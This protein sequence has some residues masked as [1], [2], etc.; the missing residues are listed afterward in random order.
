MK[1]GLST[2]TSSDGT[3]AATLALNLSHTGLQPAPVIAASVYCTYCC[4]SKIV[5]SLTASAAWCFALPQ[6]LEDM[7]PL[8]TYRGPVPPKLTAGH[9]AAVYGDELWVFPGPRNHNMMRVYCCDLT[10]YRWTER[11]VRGEPPT[12][13]ESRRNLDCFLDGKRLIVFGKISASLSSIVH[14]LTDVTWAN[15][16]TLV[17][18]HWVWQHE[19]RVDGWRMTCL[20]RIQQSAA[21]QSWHGLSLDLSRRGSTTCHSICSFSLAALPFVVLHH[22]IRQ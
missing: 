13:S 1:S 9:Y 5:V 21:S 8:Q 11:E 10:R 18:L 14:G 7:L 22:C 2:C 16:L 20:F 6:V 15:W 3:S 19:C 17:S 12:L 4:S